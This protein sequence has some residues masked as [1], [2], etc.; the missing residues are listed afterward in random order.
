MTVFKD[1]RTLAKDAMDMAIAV[2]EGKTPQTDASYNNLVKDIPA[3]QTPVVVVNKDNVKA[4][5][6]DT[7]Y[8]D[9]AKFTGLN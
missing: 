7:G 3:K 2:I 9:A 5:L 4:A 6:I 8:Y 1:T